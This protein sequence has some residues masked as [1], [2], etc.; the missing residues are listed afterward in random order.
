MKTH[1][2]G[3]YNVQDITIAA[4][5]AHRMGMTIDEIARAVEKIPPMRRNMQ[6]ISGDTYVIDDSDNAAAAGAR[7]ALDVLRDFPGRRILVTQGFGDMEENAD[8]INYE[9]GTYIP[10][11][12]DYV[13]LLDPEFTRPMMQAMLDRGFPKSAVR[14]FGEEADAAGFIAELAKTGDTV[15]Y[16]GVYPKK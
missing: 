9:L 6:L 5:V 15:L 4:C 14:M 11:C 12:A 3:A 1:L 2:L 7:V 8:E 10:G 16:E 13:V